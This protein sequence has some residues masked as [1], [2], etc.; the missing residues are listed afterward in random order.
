LVLTTLSDFGL[1]QVDGVSM[2]RLR[3]APASIAVSAIVAAAV[4]TVPV[5][6]V[7]KAQRLFTGDYSTGN[8]SQ[9]P[10]VQNIGYDGDGVHYVPTY[11]ATVVDDPAKG[12]AARFEVHTGDTPADMPSGERSEVGETSANTFTP[13]ETTRWY[14]FSIKFDPTF[15]TDHNQ[16]GWGVTNQWQSDN[17]GSPTITFG[18]ESRS[19]GGGP[20]GYWSLFQQPQTSPGVYLGQDVRLLDVPLDLGNWIDVVM[21]AHW[22]PSD[23]R[24]WVNVWVNGARQTFLTGGQTFIGRTMIPGASYVHYHEGYYRQ[25][26]IVTTGIIYH[27]N[28]RMADSQN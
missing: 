17:V 25:N 23:A 5:T 2:F 13:A 21:Q 12:K 19:G 8:F 20:D 4:I 9:W 7:A 26:G 28:F 18:W 16:L 24:G 11:S 27:A 22:S 14:A 1:T 6:P 15:P 3:P 10:S